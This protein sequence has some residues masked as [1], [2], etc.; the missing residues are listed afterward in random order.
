MGNKTRLISIYSSPGGYVDM[1]S[2]TSCWTSSFIYRTIVHRE[3][4]DYICYISLFLDY[5]TKQINVLNSV[6]LWKHYEQIKFLYLGFGLIT[7]PNLLSFSPGSRLTAFSTLALFSWTLGWVG[8][9]W[10]DGWSN[11][12][13]CCSGAGSD[14]AIRCF[15]FLWYSVPPSS[16]TT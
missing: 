9:E 6:P 16:L 11:M 10:L 7:L 2:R 14:D 13:S 1:C 12:S 8:C 15:L 4:N 5:K 3:P